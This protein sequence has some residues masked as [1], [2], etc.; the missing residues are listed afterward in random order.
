MRNQN[1]IGRIS[2]GDFRDGWDGRDGRCHTHGGLLANHVVNQND[3]SFYQFYM[4]DVWVGKSLK[5][6][7]KW[8]KIVKKHIKREEQMN[9][10]LGKTKELEETVAKMRKLQEGTSGK[11]RM[12]AGKD[13]KKKSCNNGGK[14]KL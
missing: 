5:T 9:G 8:R 13:L 12:N 10:K 4:V 6:V 14:A 7:G 11:N 3:R 2:I 1:L